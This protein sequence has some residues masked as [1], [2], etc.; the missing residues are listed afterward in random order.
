MGNR[1]KILTVKE[2]ENIERGAQ[3]DHDQFKALED[4]IDDNSATE[5]EE[6]LSDF[7]RISSS[8]GKK[9]IVPRNYVGVI[10]IKNQVQIE[11]LPKIDLEHD[12]DK[13]ELRKL[14]LKMLA[15]LKVFRGK[16]FKNAH[17]NKSH[18]PIYE[19][20]IGMYLQEVR[21]L[22]KK[23]LKSDYVTF[24]DNL[25]YFKG[26]FLVNQQIKQNLV[27]KER[28]YMA[29][30]E[31]HLNRPENK[32]IKATLLKLLHL[33][34]SSEN[35][36]LARQLLAEF[37]WIDPSVNHDKEFASVRLDRNSKDYAN[38]MTWSKVFLKNQSFSTFKGTIDVTAL[39][40][41]MEKIFEAYVAQEIRKSFTNCTVET[42]KQSAYLFDEPP[43]F[44]LKPDIYMKN[45]NRAVVMDTKWKQ[46]IANEQQNYGISQADMYQM[47]AYA[48]KYNVEDIV[49]IYPY[50]KGI[51]DIKIPN[52]Q[53]TE[54]QQ[55]DSS[56]HHLKKIIVRVFA[57]DLTDVKGSLEK[58]EQII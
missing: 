42:Q 51:K 4:F 39:L 40:F 43:K 6:R 52:Y 30:D 8:K 33:S 10:N 15:S 27:R 9:V 36:R 55:T 57:F 11:I 50:H 32:L 34:S 12:D 26:K 19:V 17:L 14:F 46:L 44:R 24:E 54:H 28:F 35:V 37:E 56:K 3:L 53:Q 21:D 23:G 47:Y 20:F 13:K 45:D 58:L 48:Y 1:M 5:S 49:L 2:Y 18:L 16:S 41:P 29:Y 22:L 25:P 31:F 7:L 38:L